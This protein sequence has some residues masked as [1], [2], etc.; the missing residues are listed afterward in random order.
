V[1]TSQEIDTLFAPLTGYVRVALAVSGGGDSVAL[2]LLAHAWAQRAPDAPALVGL[3]VDHGLRAG[4]RREAEWVA[5]QCA[6][7]GLSHHIVTWDTAHPG[8]SQ[9]EAREA[10]YRLMA[11]AARAHDINAIV[12]GHTADDVA[13]TFLMRLARGSG[14]HGLAA[15]AAETAWQG[16]PL[17]RPL[18][19]VSRAQL[20]AELDNRD[21]VWIEDPS[22]AEDRFERVRARHALDTLADLGVTRARI[23]ESA[24]R[25]R[26]ARG[27]IEAEATR[28]IEARVEVSPAGYVRFAAAELRSLPDE[29]AIHVIKR[30]LCTVGGRLRAPRLRKLETLAAH[31]RRGLDASTTLGGCVLLPDRGTVAICREP[32]RLHAAPLA[33]AAGRSGVWD[34]RFRVHCGCPRR[35][36]QVRALGESNVT[37]L[38]ETVRKNHPRAA[39]AALPGLYA[40]ETLLGVPVGGFALTDQHP[41]VAACTAEFIRNASDTAHA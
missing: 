8:A 37:A 24:N 34:G 22:N 7:L 12:T 13:E 21:A 33:V 40:D 27:V 16:V 39:L 2:M 18:L 14:I 15:M 30:L 1:L 38:P 5:A 9:A 10:R 17:I 19:G 6:A 41:D 25:L 4:S 26:R 3:T 23:V 32:G 31:L 28:F 36:I 20:R 29:T 35:A 11:E